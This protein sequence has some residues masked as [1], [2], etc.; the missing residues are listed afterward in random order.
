MGPQGL[1]LGVTN[2]SDFPNVSGGSFWRYGREGVAFSQIGWPGRVGLVVKVCRPFGAWGS[3]GGLTRGFAS[4]CT[5]GYDMP[6]LRGL[7]EAGGERF[8]VEWLP[9]VQRSAFNVLRSV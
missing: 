8:G 7:E 1:V 4:R 5:R 2:G 6:L 9:L 3:F